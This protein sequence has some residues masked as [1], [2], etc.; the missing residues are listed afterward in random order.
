VIA[1]INNKDSTVVSDSK[2]IT[3]GNGLIDRAI[4]EGK[5]ARFE[6]QGLKDDEREDELSNITINWYKQINSQQM[7]LVKSKSNPTFNDIFYET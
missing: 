4:P 2:E 7:E 3:I 6:I 5:K 1:T